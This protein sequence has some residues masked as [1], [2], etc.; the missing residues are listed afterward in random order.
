[1][2]KLHHLFHWAILAPFLSTGL[3]AS[4]TSSIQPS[5]SSQTV[6]ACAAS[7][8]EFA[9]LP[10]EFW[11]ETVFLGPV[12]VDEF[13]PFDFREDNPLRL[14]RNYVP[15]G[16]FFDNTYS[17]VV[18][19]QRNLGR[20]LFV[21]QYGTL[22]DSNIGYGQLWPYIQLSLDS[23]PGWYPF[24]FDVKCIK[25]HIFLDFTTVKV[26]SSTG[27]TELQLRAR[28]SDNSSERTFF[29]PSPSSACW[30]REGSWNHTLCRGSKETKTRKRLLNLELK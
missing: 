10:F 2:H 24:A 9:S 19:A 22:W 30:K 18:V 13:G 20:D 12:K 11:I 23:Y 8:T 21:L 16:N 4:P 7:P 28:R 17:R 5:I 27:D 25:D 3:A 26:C 15:F 6:P 29:L 1:M 14:N